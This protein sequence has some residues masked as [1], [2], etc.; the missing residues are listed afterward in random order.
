MSDR[1]R[2]RDERDS[3][4]FDNGLSAAARIYS[5]RL[6]VPAAALAGSLGI[7]AASLA[8]GAGAVL[9]VAIALFA[10]IALVR[11]SGFEEL[12]MIA[13]AGFGSAIRLFFY[14]IL[15]VILIV[16]YLASG[17]PHV[18]PDSPTLP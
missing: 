9:V 1:R 13:V 4:P 17:Q 2:E 18:P 8:F 10:L 3:L 5:R 7:S 12:A 14:L 15:V 11:Y 16:I 6:T